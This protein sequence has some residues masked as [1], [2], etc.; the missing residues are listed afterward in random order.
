[1]ATEEAQD[2]ENDNVVCDYVAEFNTNK[3][4][5]YRQGKSTGEYKERSD[6]IGQLY[7]LDCKSTAVVRFLIETDRFNSVEDLYTAATNFADPVTF[8]RAYNVSIPKDALCADHRKIFWCKVA[9]K[10][11]MVN[12]YLDTSLDK[13][14]NHCMNREMLEPWI[15]E[16]YE[17]IG[18]DN[19]ATFAYT[20]KLMIDCIEIC[21]ATINAAEQETGLAFYDAQ[22]FSRLNKHLSRMIT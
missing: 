4:S 1:M 19:G 20:N 12:F 16:G 14:L 17:V 7:K 6:H 15:G 22:A 5:F 10:W 13:A 9:Q 8:A 21:Q 11:K 2:Y 18:C 3:T